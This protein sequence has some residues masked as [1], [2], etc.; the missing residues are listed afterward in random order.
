MPTLLATAPVLLVRNVTE[1]ANYYRDKLGFTYDKLWGEPPH[2]CMVKRD[3][4]TLMLNETPANVEHLP[5]WQVVEKM[6]NAYFWVDDAKGLYEEFQKSGATIDYELGMKHYG[7]L[8]FGV[9]DIDGHDLA[10][11]QIIE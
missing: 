8:E 10:F 5:H 3:G 6:W 11:G 2:F 1:A 4:L 9:Q 7:V